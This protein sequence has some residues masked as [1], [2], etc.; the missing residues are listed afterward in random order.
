[1]S[2]GL[3]GYGAGRVYL[4]GRRWWLDFCFNGKRYRESTRQT[5]QVVAVLMLREK[6]KAL[7]KFGPLAR[8]V[9][10]GQRL[11]LGSERKAPKVKVEWPEDTGSTW[12]K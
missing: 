5:D 2:A 9:H 10:C 6:M 11:Q 3:F 8:C 12:M 7:R 1:V 4:R